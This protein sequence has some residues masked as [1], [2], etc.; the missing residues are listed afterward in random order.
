M[1]GAEGELHP[2]FGA[3]IMRI[4]GKEWHDFTL[5]HSRFLAKK[6]GKK[7]SKLCVADKMAI[8]ITPSWIYLPMVR[9]TG[10]IHEYMKMTK[11]NSDGNI[12]GMLGQMEWHEAI[13]DYVKKWVEEHKDMKDDTW[14][15]IDRHSINEKGVW[16]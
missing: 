10:E 15:S 12:Y 16:K 14:T 4:F 6:N 2:H 7:Y 8:V 11:Q 9:L 1:D 3:N 13:K 5:Y